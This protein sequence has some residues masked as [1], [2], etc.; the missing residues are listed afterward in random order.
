MPAPV[1]STSPVLRRWR[2]LLAV[3]ALTAV[4]AWWLWPSPAP[5]RQ[6]GKRPAVSKF[7]PRPVIT[8]GPDGWK[9]RSGPRLGPIATAPVADGL[10]RVTGTVRD[11]RS[12]APVA[13]VEVVFA[14]G[15]SE[16]SATADLAGRY[17]IDLPPGLYRPFVRGDSVM[18]AATP[19]RER[20]PARPRP[21]QVA[22]ARLELAAAIDLR[23]ST[24]GVDLEV[25]QAGKVRGRVVDTAGRPVAGAVVRATPTDDFAAAR[26]VLGTDVAETDAAGGFTLEVAATMYRLDAFHDRFGGVSSYVVVAVEPGATADAELT[27]VA[28]CVITGRIVRADGQP[29]GEGAL[30]RGY[31]ESSDQ[32]FPDGEF[33]P[34]GTFVW[35]TS[36]ESSFYLRAWPWK[37][38]PSQARR[39]D[40]KDGARY[41]D[42]VFEIPRAEP[43]LSGRVVDA[44]GRGVPFAFIDIVGES[45]GTMNQQERAD[46]DGNWGVFAL[47]SGSYRVSASADSRGA[48]VVRTSAPSRGVEL[49]LSGTGRIV[50]TAA[51]IDDGT[52]SLFSAGCVMDGGDYVAVEFRRVVDVRGGRFTIDEAPACELTIVA[53]H[54]GTTLQSAA[55]VPAGGQAEL[56]LDFPDTTPVLVRGVVRDADGRPVANAAI[57]AVGNRPDAEATVTDNDGRFTFEARAGDVISAS[58]QQ[59]YASQTLPAH[60]PSTVDLELRFEPAPQ[61]PVDED[62][63]RDEI[64]D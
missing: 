36:E 55:S 23:T 19:V 12:H 54:A 15:N 18:T 20:L 34:D 45:D 51:G 49:R 40:C 8:F 33:Q 26:P 64:F 61:Y 24:D 46:A 37:S 25:I 16:A 28:G 59:G 17:S 27:M 60:G 6:T 32:F 29:A 10:V 57:M 30:E 52:L 4:A 9:V 63:G 11:Q 5:A 50:G 7:R 22:A 42:V 35:S 2:W 13:D 58:S 1:T 31:G 41:A 62:Y 43:D 44:Q 53:T 38:A 48:V 14:D 47:P 21:E 3:A 56:S 39:F